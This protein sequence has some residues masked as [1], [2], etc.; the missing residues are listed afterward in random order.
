MSI[1]ETQRLLLIET[2]KEVRQ[3]FGDRDDMVIGVTAAFLDLYR[4]LFAAGLDMKELA[5]A[6]LQTQ[7]DEINRL[8]P[9]GNAARYLSAL[10]EALETD[11]LNAAKLMR[12]PAAGSA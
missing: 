8:I 9:S 10:I 3:L 1:E 12:T 7:H 6:R 5:L 2:V 11:R 4:V